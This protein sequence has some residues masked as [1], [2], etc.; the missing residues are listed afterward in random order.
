MEHPQMTEETMMDIRNRVLKSLNHRRKYGSITNEIEQCIN[1]D[2]KVIEIPI[3]RKKEVVIKAFWIKDKVPL[4]KFFEFKQIRGKVLFTE[5]C[6]NRW[7]SREIILP[8]EYNWKIQFPANF[9]GSC[10]VIPEGI[11]CCRRMI[12][13]FNDCKYITNEP[14]IPIT[15]EPPKIRTAGELVQSEMKKGNEL[16]G[17]VYNKLGCHHATPIKDVVKKCIQHNK[18]ELISI[19]VT[20]FNTVFENEFDRFDV[21]CECLRFKNPGILDFF[22]THGVDVDT[23]LA[24]SCTLLI[25]AVYKNNMPAIKVLLGRGADFNIVNNYGMNALLMAF[26]VENSGMVKFL[27]DEGASINFVDNDGNSALTYCRKYSLKSDANWK[28]LLHRIETM[29]ANGKSTDPN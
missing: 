27:L 12:V 11:I 21:L 23:Q 19:I 6:H 10:H 16:M 29:I 24:D 20:D 14:V 28:V 22:L 15:N 2:G 5:L 17:K 25:W 1:E 8:E 13:R 26:H 18:F 7:I 9:D 4:Q 3:M